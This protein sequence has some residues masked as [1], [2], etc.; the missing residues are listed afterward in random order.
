MPAFVAALAQTPARPKTLV[1]RE[2]NNQ[3]VY[4]VSRGSDLYLG[5]AEV[6]V[7]LPDQITAAIN[8]LVNG[9]DAT[10]AATSQVLGAYGITYV[11]VTNANDQS[12]IRA[13]DGSGGFA[14]SSATTNGVLWRVQGALA[15]VSF[16][17]SKNQLS[18]I[19]AASIA[20]EADVTSAG[21]IYLAE[22]Y[23]PG[24]KLLL[25][26]QPIAPVRNNFGLISFA[27]PKAGHFAIFHE[28]AQE[29]AEF[30]FEFLLLIISIVMALPAGRRRR[31]VPI[32]E[33]V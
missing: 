14:R 27:I 15:R 16:L 5:E 8:Q 20:A 3:R 23:D 9:Q 30:S 31:E 26:G 33:L 11:F 21:T 10:G 1:I 28:S 29:R 12:L 7:A 2:V 18:T 13:I 6:N 25:D 22:K 24:W 32:E 4:A 17:S 19:A